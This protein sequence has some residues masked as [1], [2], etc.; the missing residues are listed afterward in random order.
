METASRTTWTTRA[1]KGLEAVGWCKNGDYVLS[2]ECADLGIFIPNRTI[3]DTEADAVAFALQNLAYHEG[4]AVMEDY[5]W[6]HMHEELKWQVL[7]FQS[8]VRWYAHPNMTLGGLKQGQNLYEKRITAIMAFVQAV[9]GLKRKRIDQLENE[10][11]KRQKKLVTED[12]PAAAPITTASVVEPIEA[13]TGVN[14]FAVTSPTQVRSTKESPPKRR[15]VKEA[16]IL[17][18]ATAETQPLRRAV[19]SELDTPTKRKYTKKA[20]SPISIATVNSTYETPQLTPRKRSPAKKAATPPKAEPTSVESASLALLSTPKRR[21]RPP[22]SATPPTSSGAAA[23]VVPK[24]EAASTDVPS[25]P[26]QRGRSPKAAKGEATDIPSTPKRRG[27][28]AKASSPALITTPVKNALPPRAASPMATLARSPGVAKRGRPAA[29]S[30]VLEVAST[31]PKK[32]KTPKSAAKSDAAAL[33]KAEAKPEAKPEF[34]PFEQLQ[35]P[36]T[37]VKA[38]FPLNLLSGSPSHGLSTPKRQPRTPPSVSLFGSPAETKVSESEWQPI[39]DK[40][41]RRGSGSPGRR[42]STPVKTPTARRPPLPPSTDATSPMSISHILSTSEVDADRSMHC[43]VQRNLN[44]SCFREAA[45]D[46]DMANFLNKTVQDSPAVKRESHFETMSTVMNDLLDGAYSHLTHESPC[47]VRRPVP[48]P[49]TPECDVAKSVPIFTPPKEVN[50]VFR[51]RVLTTFLSSGWRSVAP[52]MNGTG[53]YYYT[54]KALNGKSISRQDLE[55]YAIENDVFQRDANKD[56]L[57]VLAWVSRHHSPVKGPTVNR[58]L[59]SPSPLRRFSFP[60]S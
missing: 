56:P 36:L 40:K 25:T 50:V 18:E 14:P 12:T 5:I 27:R 49:F 34:A 20:P 21:G 46:D 11:Q 54:H 32:Q 15:T 6:D 19:K 44:R 24:V 37:P 47:V 7:R 26:K 23:D 28:P 43:N 13:P 48:D 30:P 45:S 10:M 16:D 35:V 57:A 51:R 55:Q 60:T 9:L 17:T 59:L 2:P 29:A 4:L 42:H 22:K 33:V 1:W 52:P 8:G 39:F 53:N 31:A 3:F 58:K 41:H 38:S